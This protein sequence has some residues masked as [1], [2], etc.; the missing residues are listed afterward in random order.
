MMYS[1][2]RL[3]TAFRVRPVSVCVAFTEAPGT[4]APVGSSTVPRMLPVICWAAALKAKKTVSRIQIRPLQA[5]MRWRTF[6]PLNPHTN[7]RN[8]IPPRPGRH[9][10]SLTTLNAIRFFRDPK[11]T[12]SRAAK[13]YPS[14]PRRTITQNYYGCMSGCD[15]DSVHFQAQ[16]QFAREIVDDPDFLSC[17]TWNVRDGHGQLAGKQHSRKRLAHFTVHL[18]GDSAAGGRFLTL[19]AVKR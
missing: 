1:P 19:A 6:P 7:F 13:R 16:P 9:K 3:V 18:F 2:E 14:T 12:E 8:K 11:S 4:V 5:G 15:T 17:G 10:V